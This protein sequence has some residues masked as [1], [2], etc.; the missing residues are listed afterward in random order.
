MEAA[1]PMSDDLYGNSLRLVIPRLEIKNLS[2][3]YSMSQSCFWRIEPPLTLSPSQSEETDR[4]DALNAALQTHPQ[5]LINVQVNEVI[6]LMINS[7]VDFF[8]Q[9]YQDYHAY[10]VVELNP[11]ILKLKEIIFYSTNQSALAIKY[12]ELIGRIKSDLVLVWSGWEEHKSYFFP[13]NTGR[14][15]LHDV[16]DII[17]K[18]FRLDTLTKALE[19]GPTFEWHRVQL[20]KEVDEIKLF[21]DMISKDEIFIIYATKFQKFEI[22]SLL[23][24]SY[25]VLSISGFFFRIEIKDLDDILLQELART[26]SSSFILQFLPDNRKIINIIK[27]NLLEFFMRNSEKIFMPALRALRDEPELQKLR[28]D[29]GGSKRVNKSRKNKYKRKHKY[30]HKY[31]K[32]R[33]NKRHR[34]KRTQSNQNKMF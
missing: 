29:E 11:L 32:S 27:T 15:L 4:G 14:E 17:K 8:I 21:L 5:L 7:F 23:F 18:K 31:K 25:H 12:N 20:Q 3:E 6:I 10:N 22:F 16:E 26:P 19:V 9:Y 34:R 33:K 24:L 2:V 13:K 30:N 1:E 28:P